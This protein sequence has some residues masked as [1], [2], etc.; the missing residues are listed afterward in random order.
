[1]GNCIFVNKSVSGSLHPLFSQVYLFAIDPHNYNT[2]FASNGLLKILTNDTSIYGT[3]SFETSTITS[4]FFF[5]SHF[6]VINLK[7]TSLNQIKDLIKNYFFNLHD[8]LVT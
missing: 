8:N 3:K 2:R 4:S 6:T 7:E 1:M 5:Q